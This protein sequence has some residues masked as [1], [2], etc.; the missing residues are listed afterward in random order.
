MKLKLSDKVRQNKKLLKK[1]KKGQNLPEKAN[2]TAKKINN[3]KGIQKT[4]MNSILAKRLF[5]IGHRRD[6]LNT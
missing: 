6:K 2:F 4:L 1:T 3:L 5:N